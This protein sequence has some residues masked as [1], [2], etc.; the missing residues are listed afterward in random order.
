MIKFPI[1]LAWSIAVSLPLAGAAE[2]IDYK[3]L[4]KQ[5]QK[6]AITEQTLPKRDQSNRFDG[7]PDAIALG[8]RLFF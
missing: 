2:G 4:A 8:Q 6:F 3:L 5:A 1:V 7:N